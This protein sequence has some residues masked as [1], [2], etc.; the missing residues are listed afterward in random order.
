M[1]QAAAGNAIML[2]DISG[3][4]MGGAWGAD[5]TMIVGTMGGVDHSRGAHGLRGGARSCRWSRWTLERSLPDRG[6]VLSVENYVGDKVQ[7]SIGGRR[8]R[9]AT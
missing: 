8:D 9:E 7:G 2:A 6:V 1:A 3:Q 5:G 4:V